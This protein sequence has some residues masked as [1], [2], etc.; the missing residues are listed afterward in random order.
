MVKNKTITSFF[1]RTNEEQQVEGIDDEIQESK[2]Q[3]GSTSEP[4]IGPAACNE[5]PSEIP[6]ANI[7]E[8]DVSSLERDPA[9][10]LEMWK[11]PVMVREQVRQAYISLGVYQPKL[12][13]YKPRGPKNNIRRFKFAWFGM[14]PNWLEYSPTTHKTY[15]FLCYMYKEKPNEKS[16]HSAFSCEGFD[17]WKKVNDGIFYMKRS[18]HR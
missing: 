3:K 6:Q 14:F 17:N 7:N 12:E 15:C 5:Q 1:K 10:R 18:S 13:E 2:R 8:V 16:G 11:Y 9:K 4:V